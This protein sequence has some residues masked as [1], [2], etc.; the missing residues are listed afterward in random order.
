MERIG[1]GKL[2]TKE[3]E[4][5]LARQARAGNED[6]HRRLV[7]KNLR[8]VV[9]VAKRYRGMGL[10]FEDLI[11]EGNIGLMIAVERF[12]P[13]MGNRFSTYATWWIR[14]TIVRAIADKGRVVRLPVHV[15]E[16]ARKAARVRSELSAQ[17]G[18]EPA[19]EEVAARLGWTAGEAR[20]AIG[21]LPDA[22]SLDQPV[23]GEESASELGEFVEDE[24]AS[25]MPDAVIR[26]ME[27]ARLREAIEGMPDRERHVL[28]RRHGLD[29]REPATLAELG[30]ELGVTRERVR[31]LQ[32]KAERR[33]RTS[34]THAYVAPE[35]C[36]RDASRQRPLVRDKEVIQMAKPG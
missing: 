26:E 27:N 8:L 4:L 35:R 9:S 34:M 30:A 3:E 17:L 24:G 16:K 11:Q 6:A 18:R 36:R 2:L 31:Q 22:T 7:E 28:V 19:H 21:F 14:Q 15:G 33:L 12:D 29:D 13:E 25:D 20:A 23:S 10:P 32:R 1:R 5:N